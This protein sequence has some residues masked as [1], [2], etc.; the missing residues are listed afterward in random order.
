MTNE[1]R[2]CNGSS[3]TIQNPG[4]ISKYASLGYFHLGYIKSINRLNSCENIVRDLGVLKSKTN[5]NQGESYIKISL[6]DF[7][8]KRKHTFLLSY[9]GHRSRITIGDIIDILYLLCKSSMNDVSESYVKFDM[10]SY[11]YSDLN[12]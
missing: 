7:G 5:T 2:L 6:V 3:C 9:Y 1:F 12:N 10:Y 8:I 11:V 4:T